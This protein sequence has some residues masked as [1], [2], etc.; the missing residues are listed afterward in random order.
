LIRIW[1]AKREKTQNNNDRP[2]FFGTID[3]EFSEDKLLQLR[4][5][6]D[7]EGIKKYI[8]SFYAKVSN[9]KFVVYHCRSE[10]KYDYIDD[11]IFRTKILKPLEIKKSRLQVG[12]PCLFGRPWPVWP[13]KTKSL[14]KTFVADQRFSHKCNRHS[15]TV[16]ITKLHYNTQHFT[17][18]FCFLLFQSFQEIK[19]IT[20]KIAL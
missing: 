18:F 19:N 7:I 2:I 11:Y 3:G 15:A 9:A 16:S 4:E 17:I 14:T 1:F 8:A 5:D 12:R 10:N 13:A 6:N 20:N